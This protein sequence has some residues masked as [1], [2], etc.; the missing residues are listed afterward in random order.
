MVPPPWPADSMP[1]PLLPLSTFLERLF[2]AEP[3]YHQ[4][5][6]DVLCPLALSLCTTAYQSGPVGCHLRRFVSILVIPVAVFFVFVQRQLMEGLGLPP[7]SR[8]HKWSGCSGLPTPA[9]HTGAVP[10]RAQPAARGSGLGRPRVYPTP[11]AETASSSS[12][13]SLILSDLLGPGCLRQN[14]PRKRSQPC[15]PV[16]VHSFDELAG[17]FYGVWLQF[18]YVGT[19]RMLSCHRPD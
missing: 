6:A 9:V 8:C 13:V 14:Q 4:P 19:G 7:I 16:A 5:G 15:G 18:L 10:S 1:P 11:S 12:A 2:L 3:L 17:P